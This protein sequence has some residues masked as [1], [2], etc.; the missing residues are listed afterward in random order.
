MPFFT[1]VDVSDRSDRSDKS[2]KSDRSDKHDLQHRS[3]F[4]LT[5]SEGTR[6]E[7]NQGSE[8]ESHEQAGFRHG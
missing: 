3:I 1:G 4:S 2:D 6:T 7:Y 8:S 5:N